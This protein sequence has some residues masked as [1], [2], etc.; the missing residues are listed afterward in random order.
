LVILKK[1]RVVTAA[2]HR[3]VLQEPKPVKEIVIVREKSKK[4]EKVIEVNQPIQ[5]NQAYAPMYSTSP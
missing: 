5:I 4:R 1:D 2:T 3:G